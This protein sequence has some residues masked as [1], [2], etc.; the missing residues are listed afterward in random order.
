[1]IW[2]VLWFALVA[3]AIS[4][5]SYLVVG[6]IVEARAAGSSGP[7]MIRDVLGQNAHHL[8]GMVM[9]PSPCDELTTRTESISSTTY[10]LVFATWRE[11]SVNCTADETPRSF[12]AIVFGPAADIG[13]AATL[14]G[15]GI[16]I[17]VMPTLPQ[18]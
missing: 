15:A 14:D 16:P 10:M 4:Y 7:V 18:R 8:S 11:P 13:F 6:S 2:R 1:M 12:H 9:V 3:T 5:A 17:V